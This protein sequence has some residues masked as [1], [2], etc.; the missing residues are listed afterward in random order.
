M[1]R[2]Q[3]WVADDGTVF[4]DE[5]ACEEYEAKQKTRDLV[6][7]FVGQYLG[8][9]LKTDKLIEE[10]E[11]WRRA[12]ERE[13]SKPKRTAAPLPIN[14]LAS[15]LLCSEEDAAWL[16]EERK[17]LV[18][19]VHVVGGSQAIESRQAF[20]EINPQVAAWFHANGIKEW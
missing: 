12:R 14:L 9:P 19:E 5:A 13:Q 15:V 11:K 20:D 4:T 8:E 17:R 16:V 3:A 10:W 6:K 1:K 7:E 18:R 2:T